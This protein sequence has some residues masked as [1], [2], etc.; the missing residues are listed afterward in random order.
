MDYRISMKWTTKNE[1]IETV[2]KYKSKNGWVNMEPQSLRRIVNDDMNT[3]RNRIWI[4]RT[5]QSTRPWNKTATVAIE[6]DFWSSTYCHRAQNPYFFLQ[7][8]Y[9][10]CSFVTYPCEYLCTYVTT[11]A[12]SNV[13]ILLRYAYLLKSMLML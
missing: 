9:I 10:F 8:R 7:E 13:K 12:I 5:V 1:T 4:N 6:I 11:H 3:Q 2:A